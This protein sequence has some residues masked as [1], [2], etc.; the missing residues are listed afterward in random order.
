M[1]MTLNV[2]FIKIA[3]AIGDTKWTEVNIIIVKKMIGSYGS[4]LKSKVWLGSIKHNEEID[5]LHVNILS[6]L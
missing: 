4:L 5:S 3:S 2:H 6:L 1:G